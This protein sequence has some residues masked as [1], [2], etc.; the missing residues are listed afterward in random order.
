[1]WCFQE[2]LLYQA[3]HFP[4]PVIV[5]PLPRLSLALFPLLPWALSSLRPRPFLMPRE[6][7][8][9]A[10]RTPYI[11]TRPW[12]QTQG[13]RLSEDTHSHIHTHTQSESLKGFLILSELSSLC[14]PEPILLSDC[15]ET[16]QKKKV[17]FI[18]RKRF[19]IRQ[20]LK[21][22]F[23]WKKKCTKPNIHI[24]FRV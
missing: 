3:C 5:P 14:H 11:D 7:E 18:L 22:K 4:P 23:E 2:A 15:T 20:N 8:Q 6:R 17:Q 10:T 13:K 16:I 21:L 19:T 12:R 9:A 24:Y 1:M